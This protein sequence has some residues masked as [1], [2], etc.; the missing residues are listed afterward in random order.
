MGKITLQNEDLETNTIKLLRLV[1]SVFV[2]FLHSQIVDFTVLGK[3]ISLL[4]Q[5]TEFY[6]QTQSFIIKII[7]GVSPPL[8]FFIS[9]FFYF[10]NLKDWDWKIYWAKT[11][12]RSK[13]L[14][15]PYIFWCCFV[16]LVI[17][18][19]QELSFTS[20]YLSGNNA[21]I[22]EYKTI[23]FIKLFWALPLIDTINDTVS[24]LPVLGVL[25]FIRD[26][27]VVSILSPLI[28]VLIHYMN[29]I[30]IFCLGILWIFCFNTYII[31][32]S[33]IS[34]FFFAGG[35]YMSI[36]NINFIFLFRKRMKLFM[37]LTLIFILLDYF[38]K[39][40]SYNI[41]I[42]HLSVII[43]MISIINIAS[44]IIKYKNIRI[45][46]YWIGASF[47][48]YVTHEPWLAFLR[49]INL[50]IFPHTNL[51]FFLIFI[52]QALLII[53][54][55]LTVYYLLYKL[56]PNFLKIIT[57]GRIVKKTYN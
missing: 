1:L 37:I 19:G 10:R 44:Y 20:N 18:I 57:G 27:I 11:K 33:V 28:W 56:T 53:C 2:V 15:F 48:L 47:F 29:Y 21:L 42:T 41:Y 17:F 39:T 32:L 26:L 38:T 12:N 25:W 8:F 54:I 55:S 14:L 36:N 49:K 23:D 3:S 43:R 13:T 52:F 5:H 51:S 9:G 16:S 34:F 45:T 30:G 50:L 6:F 40:A 35:A 22:R 31:G 24:Y 7:G 4:N 46:Y